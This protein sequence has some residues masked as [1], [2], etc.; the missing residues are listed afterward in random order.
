MSLDKNYS[1]VWPAVMMQTKEGL[2]LLSQRPLPSSVFSQASD[3]NHHDFRFLAWKM[4]M[5]FIMLRGCFETWVKC[6]MK[7]KMTESSA[8]H[9]TV[10]RKM[11]LVLPD[12]HIQRCIQ[13]AHCLT[14]GRFSVND[15]YGFCLVVWFLY[16]ASFLF[17]LLYFFSLG[18]ARK[19]HPLCALYPSSVALSSLKYGH[20]DFCKGL[21]WWHRLERP[22]NPSFS[23]WIQGKREK[24][25]AL[26]GPLHQSN[27]NVCIREM[28]LNFMLGI[29]VPCLLP[30][31]MACWN[32]G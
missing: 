14:R 30:L 2:Y 17:M 15:Y 26:T 10:L 28:E 21:N 12:N 11:E 3:W 6:N 29:H 9:V 18:R 27:K 4:G 1:V 22:I 31:G 13:R 23:D 16:L 8:S 24:Q 20:G 32:K 7:H 5:I 19:L 25:F